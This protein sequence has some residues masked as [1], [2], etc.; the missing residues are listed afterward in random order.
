MSA[1]EQFERLDQRFARQA[2][3]AVERRVQF[4]YQKNRGRKRKCTSNRCSVDVRLLGAK[5]ASAMYS[6]ASH[7][8]S[9]KRKAGGIDPLARSAKSTRARLSSELRV[10]ARACSQRC[11]SVAGESASN[12]CCNRPICGN[13]AAVTSRTCSR[14]VRRNGAIDGA[15]RESAQQFACSLWLLPVLG[16][17]MVDQQDV[18]RQFRS[19]TPCRH[20]TKSLHWS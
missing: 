16:Q 8:V 12:D 13:G 7:A 6:I 3:Q 9:T 10:S 14:L 20:Q 11:A 1:A 2:D 17:S 5:M 19:P 4:E 18:G 15:F